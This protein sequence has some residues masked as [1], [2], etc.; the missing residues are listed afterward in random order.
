MSGLLNTPVYKRR[1]IHKP[2]PSI[3]LRG[4]EF[5]SNGLRSR[6][7]L[8]HELRQVQR[9]GR[10]HFLRLDRARQDLLF[11]REPDDG[12]QRLTI[13]LQAVGERIV[14]HEAST[15]GQNLSIGR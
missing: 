9:V 14:T 12:L 2:L 8:S 4:G 11:V 10:E 7:R 3:C 1:H 6:H 5:L 13:A 15:P